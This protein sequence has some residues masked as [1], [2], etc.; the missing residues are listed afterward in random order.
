MVPF[1]NKEGGQHSISDLGTKPQG[2]T[3]DYHTHGAEG[4]PDYDDE[5]FSDAAK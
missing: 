5:N 4:G 2:T 3:A 1:L